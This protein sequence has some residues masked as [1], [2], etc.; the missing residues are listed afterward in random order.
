MRF[1]VT[2]LLALFFSSG[3]SAQSLVHPSVGESVTTSDNKVKII[4]I[5]KKQNFSMH[6]STYDPDINS[7]K[8]VHIHPNGKKYYVNSLEGCTTISYDFTT[9][10]KLR[11]IRHSFDE[12]RDA[13]LWS[14]PSGLFPWTHYSENLNTFYG[15]PV[16][17]TYSHAGAYLWV[18]YYRRSFD[19]NAQDPSAVAIID[20]ET[21]SIV[22]LME[23]GPLPKMITTSPDGNIVAISHWGNN[24]VGLIDISSSNPADWKYICKLVVDYELKLNYPLDHSVDRDN[25]SGYALRGTVFTPDNK[26]LF[27]GCMGN[28][29]GIAVIDIPQRKYLGRVLG[30]MPNVRHIVLSNGYLYLSINK[31][32]AVQRISLEKF[33]DAASRLDGKTTSLSGWETAKVGTGAR[34]IS[35]TPNGQYVFAACNNASGI[36]IVDTETM[37]TI[38]HIDADSYPVGLDIS[39]DGTYVFSTSQGRD[40]GGGNCVDIYKVEYQDDVTKRGCLACGGAMSDNGN[41]CLACGLK[42]SSSPASEASSSDKPLDA[43]SDVTQASEGVQPA[44]ATGCASQIMQAIA[45]YRIILP[46]AAA[47]LALI[48]LIAFVVHRSSRM[49]KSA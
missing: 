25:G 28:D 13:A 42:L 32:G 9:N 23:T 39:S 1:P 15:K 40:N 27:V 8:S 44:A 16:E 45:D 6:G 5:D 12:V 22:R 19:I 17:S 29:G 43:G 38:G 37:T 3:L 26:Y 48:A 35:L 24:T 46:T 34:T 30:M 49:K 7:P 4:L 10:R 2:I 41:E 33:L 31:G 14:E 11:V 47:V 18:P 21:D 20:T 36:Y